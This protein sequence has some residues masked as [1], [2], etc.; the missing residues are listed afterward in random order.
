M[1]NKLINNQSL[2]KIHQYEN[3]NN[4]IHKIEI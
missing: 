4:V 2:L 3:F 1:L